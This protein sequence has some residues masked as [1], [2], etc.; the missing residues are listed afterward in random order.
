MVV[1]CQNQSGQGAALRMLEP[2][3]PLTQNCRHDAARKGDPGAGPVRGTDGFD[4]SDFHYVNGT[5]LMATLYG[6]DVLA[7]AR[8]QQ[9]PE[10]LLSGPNEGQNLGSLVNSSGT[11][12]NAQL[13][14][15]RRIPSIALSADADTANHAALSA[16]VAQL[17]VRLVQTL[18]AR[19]SG[20]PLLPDGIGFNVN[21]PRFAAGTAARLRWT[22]TRRGD[23]ETRTLRFVPNLAQH[24]AGRAGKL[25]AYPGLVI[26]PV[27][28]PPTAQQR[29]DEAAVVLAGRIA[30]TPMQLGF[31]ALTQDR[32][33]LRKRMQS[34]LRR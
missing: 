24:P 16:D 27:P 32:E 15:A 29:D 9:V 25:G 2:L 23:Y 30:V 20:Q 18:Q 7:P 34:L 21:V 31:E 3:K 26:E 17:G 1:P 19:A 12:S 4:S 5:P 6:L 33:T 10:L 11:V 22:L 8:W 14:L 13:G 28:T